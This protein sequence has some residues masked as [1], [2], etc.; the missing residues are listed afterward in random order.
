M[1]LLGWPGLELKGGG[2][3]GLGASGRSCGGWRAGVGLGAPL[4]GTDVPRQVVLEQGQQQPFGLLA[5]L[6]S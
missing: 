1:L 2:G 5:C 6:Y 4:D 3:G